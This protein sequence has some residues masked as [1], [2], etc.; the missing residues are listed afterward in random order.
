MN[1]EDK[2]NSKTE[3][4]IKNEA[5]NHI[6]GSMGFMGNLGAIDFRGIPNVES[7]D[8]AVDLP[9]SNFRGNPKAEDKDSAEDFLKDTPYSANKGFTPSP[10][11]TPEQFEATKI[12]PSSKDEITFEGFPKPES[13][14]NVDQSIVDFLQGS[15]Y[16]VLKDFKPSPMPTPE[17]FEATAKGLSDAA[18]QILKIR[19]QATESQP[20]TDNKNKP[21]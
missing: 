5:V 18:K 9:P 14:A 19:G 7:L 20:S 11:N 1:N 6:V 3:E 13:N 2:Q 12:T 4:E 21:Q 10:M 15:P 17:Q 8:S 16:E